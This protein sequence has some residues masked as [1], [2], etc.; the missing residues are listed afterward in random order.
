MDDDDP[1]AQYRKGPSTRREKPAAPERPAPEGEGGRRPYLAFDSKDKVVCLDIRRVLGTTHCPTYNYLLNIAYD[2]EFYRTFVLYF[3]F[4]QVKVSGKNLREV[5]NAIK[6]RK[7]EWIQ[8]FHPRDFEPPKEGE[9][10]IESITVEWRDPVMP[11]R[12]GEQG[13]AEGSKP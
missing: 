1:L 12:E 8:D 5:V 6:L 10:L 2:Y 7:C 9:P 3:S 11:G 4:M 13:R